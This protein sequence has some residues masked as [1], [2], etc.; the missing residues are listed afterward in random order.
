[1]A[2]RQRTR[3][4]R[5][6]A[7]AALVAIGAAGA[8]A[9]AGGRTAVVVERPGAAPDL[10]L[11]LERPPRSRDPSLLSDW[12]EHAALRPLRRLVNPPGL[13]RRAVGAG[14]EAYNVTAEDDVA[15]PAWFVHRNSRSAMA[16]AE[17]ARGPNRGA[18]PDTSGVWTV[19]RGKVEG[20][21]PGFWIRDRRGDAYLVKFDPPGHPEMATA[22]E[23]IS[24]RLLHAAGYH[25]PELYVAAMDV[26]RIRAEPSLAFPDERGRPQPV[27]DRDLHALLRPLQR[28]DG[29]VRAL[30]SRELPGALGPFAYEGTRDDDPADTIPH[31]HRRELRGLYVLAAWLDHFDVK[32]HNTLDTFVR[33]EDGRGFVR[34]HLMD[35][36]STLGSRSLGPQTP[37]T[38]VEGD[39]DWTRM[40]LRAVTGGFYASRWER[41][42]PPPMHPSVGSYSAELFDPGAW[43][44]GIPNPAFD[45][46]TVR[47]AYWGAKLVS[48]FGEE[49]IRAAVAAGRLSDPTAEEALVRALIERRDRT[50]RHW[51]LRVTPLD[52]PRV[53][54]GAAQPTLE[55]R[56]LALAEGI[57]PAG[58]RRYRVELELP[59]VGRRDLRAPALEA[60]GRGRLSLP[61]PGATDPP[62]WSRIDGL[63]VE[64][65]IA[66]LEVRAVPRPGD[67]QTRSV[68]IYLLPDRER[69]YRVVGYAY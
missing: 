18:G 48:G 14:T 54:G 12:T 4:P 43:V 46:M 55:F 27:G 11:R 56:E 58:E 59:G 6:A 10:E 22:A 21:T 47:D 66:R 9:C 36:G 64:E 33:D 35:F 68:R 69:G 41:F 63:P 37:R 13:L 38:G 1:M 31:Q 15:D 57:V 25:T 65:R 30:A 39:V 29:K 17:I 67:P 19:F 62:L 24:G 28:P 42:D 3:R 49:Q 61:P 20:V 23:A 53:T 16:P 45:R 7:G 8:L 26:G 2:V 34:H 51:F 5:L 60:D 52:A 32:Q 40:I 50:V 44:P